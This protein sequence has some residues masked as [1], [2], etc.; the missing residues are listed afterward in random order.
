MWQE[1]SNTLVLCPIK[2]ENCIA[3]VAQ[4]QFYDFINTLQQIIA[5]PR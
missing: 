3:V 4:R 5:A 2:P 1:Y